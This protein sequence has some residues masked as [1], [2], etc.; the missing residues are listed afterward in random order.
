[1]GLEQQREIRNE[2]K[3]AK[4]SS[5][6]IKEMRKNEKRRNS[7]IVFKFKKPSYVREILII[8]MNFLSSKL[9]IDARG[10]DGNSFVD[11]SDKNVANIEFY[12]FLDK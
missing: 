2:L 12:R 7:N 4:Y 11:S 10:R 6:E 8:W 1:M 3:P 5:D 9:K